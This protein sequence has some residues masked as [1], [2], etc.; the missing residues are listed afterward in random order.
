MAVRRGNSVGVNW[1]TKWDKLK[2]PMILS[3]TDAPEESDL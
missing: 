1:L 2:N 3:E